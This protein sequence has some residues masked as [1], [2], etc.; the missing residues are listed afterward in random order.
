MPEF[1]I[2]GGSAHL[3]PDWKEKVRAPEAPS[4][5]RKQEVIDEYV[6][7]KME[8][9]EYEVAQS[10]PSVMVVDNL[11]VAWTCGLSLPEFPTVE[12]YILAAHDKV[13]DY[14]VRLTIIGDKNLLLAHVAN[15]RLDDSIAKR[16][17]RY[18][19]WSGKMNVMSLEDFR[20][21]AAERKM[22][23]TDRFIPRNPNDPYIDFV[24]EN[25]QDWGLASPD[26]WARFVNGTLQPAEF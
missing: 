13:F 18:R 25:L 1:M 15:V 26:E 10:C 20:F 17:L 21:T 14:N 22:L 9:L 24:I 2:I 16:D 7:N 12:D 23:L 19:L 4:N 8:T 6:R 5:Y 3:S 11:S